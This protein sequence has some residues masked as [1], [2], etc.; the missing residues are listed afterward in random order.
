M[1]NDK[2]LVT[3]LHGM[4]KVPIVPLPHFKALSCDICQVAWRIGEVKPDISKTK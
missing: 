2:Y 4:R 1:R 3:N